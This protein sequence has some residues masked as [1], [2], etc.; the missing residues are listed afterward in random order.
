MSR[1]AAPKLSLALPLSVLALLPLACGDDGRTEGDDEIGLTSTDSDSDG[2]DSESST[3]L[4]T[5]TT[6]DTDTTGC[7]APCGDDCCGDGEVCDLDDLVCVIDCGDDP[8][9]GDAPGQC[10]SAG[11]VCYAG[12]C[13]VP[14]A[15]CMVSSCATDTRSSCGVGEVCDPDLGACVPDLADQTCTYQPEAGVFDPVPRFSWG[16]RK[17]RACMTDMDCQKE[18][19]CDMGTCAVTWPHITPAMDD[20]P[21]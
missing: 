12:G 19:I 5:T 7:D 18:E 2:S 13:I 17:V 3:T 11:E 4:D 9:C 10:C 1:P 20:E 8:V 14:G 16:A 6:L 21:T 15:D